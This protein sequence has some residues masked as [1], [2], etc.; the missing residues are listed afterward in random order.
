MVL[1]ST[2]PNMFLRKFP[3]R[4]RAFTLIELLI[5]VAIIAI[6][7]SLM[8]SA[9]QRVR[10]AADR[11]TCTNNLKQIGVAANH[12]HDVYRTLPRMRLC[13][14]KSWFDGKDPYCYRDASGSGMTY[15]GPA[16]IWWAPYDNRPGT[17][18][19]YALPDY[20]PRGLLLPFAEGKISIFRCPRAREWG[21]KSWE[22]LVPQVSYAWNGVTNGPAG[23]RLSDLA[24]GNGASHVSVVWDHVIGPHC[25]TGFPTARRWNDPIWDTAFV[26]YPVQWHLG[27]CNFLF[28]DGHVGGITHGE[29]GKGMFY[30]NEQ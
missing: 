10:A 29:I 15:T 19:S 14:D 2:F 26:H 11:I 30:V 25:W 16:E 20:D 1:C 18:N 28:C 8:L 5:V 4:A 21:I 17:T 9:A 24:N 6:V 13:L 3:T 7:S 23:K 27:V 22:Y 12:Y